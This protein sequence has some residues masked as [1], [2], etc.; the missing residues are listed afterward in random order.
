MQYAECHVL[1]HL[2]EEGGERRG[3]EEWGERRGGRGG[4]ERRQRQR[5]KE[6]QTC[7]YKTT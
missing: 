7:I 3:G 6:I 2:G 5:D 4:G 1:E